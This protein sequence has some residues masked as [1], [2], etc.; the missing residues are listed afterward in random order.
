[1]IKIV[2]S[3]NEFTVGE[4]LELPPTLEKILVEIRELAIYVE[5]EITENIENNKNEVVLDSNV[6]SKNSDKK[7]LKRDAISKPSNKRTRK[8]KSN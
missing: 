4:V 1:M 8:S 2:K 3:F 5:P 7:E 6:K